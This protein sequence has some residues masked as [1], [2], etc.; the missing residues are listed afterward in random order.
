MEHSDKVLTLKRF[1]EDFLKC[2]LGNY[3]NQQKYYK[4]YIED[5]VDNE[6]VSISFNEDYFYIFSLL[7]KYFKVFKDEFDKQNLSFVESSE[8]LND[9]VKIQLDF[10]IIKPVATEHNIHITIVYK[11]IFHHY[12]ESFLKSKPTQI[13]ISVL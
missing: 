11:Q 4:Q 12:S 13:T 6:K 2:G 8:K 10:D 3:S 9:L 5:K 7:Q 1:L